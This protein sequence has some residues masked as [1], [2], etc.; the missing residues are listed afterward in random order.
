LM[1]GGQNRSLGAT[2]LHAPGVS[3]GI[4]GQISIRGE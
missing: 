1:P 2:L 4:N 3:P